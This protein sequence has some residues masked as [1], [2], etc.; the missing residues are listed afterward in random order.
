MQVTVTLPV[1]QE[2]WGRL[3]S[4]TPPLWSSYLKHS[5]WWL[6]LATV[7]SWCTFLS[8]SPRCVGFGRILYFG[9]LFG[10][11]DG[12]NLCVLQLSSYSLKAFFTLQKINIYENMTKIVPKINLLTFYSKFEALTNIYQNKLKRLLDIHIIIIT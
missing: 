2:S 1:R 9:M 4:S 11:F 7:T 6:Y 3:V 8:I 10:C 12:V 5:R